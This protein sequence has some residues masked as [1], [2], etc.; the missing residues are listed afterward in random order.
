VAGN[1]HS[2]GSWS[3]VDAAGA[4]FIQHMKARGCPVWRAQGLGW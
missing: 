1:P 2:V 3:H 4:P